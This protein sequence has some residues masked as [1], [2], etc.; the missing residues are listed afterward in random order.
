ML[1]GKEEG[2]VEGVLYY[3]IVAVEDED[4]GCSALGGLSIILL[5]RRV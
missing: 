5:C 3:L 4:D 2:M 1:C